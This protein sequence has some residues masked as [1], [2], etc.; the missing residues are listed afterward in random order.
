[1]A[2]IK[3]KPICAVLVS[4]GICIS[5]ASTA[6]SA[7]A[8]PEDSVS[9][10]AE[11]AAAS[12]YC[13]VFSSSEISS[14]LNGEQ[15]HAV[16]IAEMDSEFSAAELSPRCEWENTAATATVSD[17]LSELTASDKGRFI[18]LDNGKFLYPAEDSMWLSSQEWTQLTKQLNQPVSLATVR[19]LLQRTKA[20]SDFLWNHYTPLS[21]TAYSETIDAFFPEFSKI[22]VSNQAAVKYWLNTDANCTTYDSS[23]FHALL[24]ECLHEQS[25]RMSGVFA[26]RYAQSSIWAVEWQAKPPVMYYYDLETRSWNGVTLQDVPAANSLLSGA[27]DA[28]KKSVYYSEYTK[29]NTVSNDYGIYGMLQE[30]CSAAVD[31]RVE[32][33]SSSLT[34]HFQKISEDQFQE[35]YWWKGAI[36][37]YLDALSTADSKAYN[38][39]VQDKALMNLLN[40][41]F[42][43]TEHQFSMALIKTD[44]SETTVALRNYANEL[45]WS[46]FFSS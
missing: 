16:M 8:T 39:L 40:D 29:D 3:I 33:V 31:L 18:R 27:S 6:Y 5:L 36:L 43:Y 28:V 46:S 41:T 38:K 42:S 22:I 17:F 2:K 13:S 45:N 24:H 1:M 20:A 37:H 19:V 12:S 14:V 44:S 23:H 4:L 25:A 7:P 10:P 35:Y 15:D 32:I 34:Y 11:S 9:V 26:R 21:Y 30:F